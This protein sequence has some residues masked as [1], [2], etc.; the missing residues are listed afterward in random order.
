MKARVL[1]VVC[2]ILSSELSAS[3]LPMADNRSMSL[4][5]RLKSERR[6]ARRDGDLDQWY[7]LN[8]GNRGPYAL[9]AR[10]P[11]VTPWWSKGRVEHRAFDT[12][13]GGMIP[14]VD[15]RYVIETADAEKKSYPKVETRQFD[16]LGGGEIPWMDRRSPQN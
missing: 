3:A 5:D 10:K 16:T 15:K 8:D 1:L 9:P 6:S 13:G 4:G 2:V 14:L 11:Q 7:Y 12:L